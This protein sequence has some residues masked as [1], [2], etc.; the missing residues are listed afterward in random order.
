MADILTKQP[1]VAHS[2][3]QFA[4]SQPEH[5]NWLHF[6]EVSAG[7][8][9]VHVVILLVLIGLAAIPSPTYRAP[10][11]SIRFN[12][13]DAAKLVAPP[14]SVLTQKD[15]NK[16]K[17]STEFNVA[18]LSPRPSQPNT[19]SSPGAAALP[20]QKLTLP[21]KKMPLPSVP[22]VTPDAPSIDTSQL[23]AAAPPPPALGTQPGPP[24]QIQPTEKPKLAFERP[25]VPMG[26]SAPAGVGK[27]PVPS[28]SRSVEDAARQVA[29]GG[30]RGLI[31]GDEDA[32]TL[33]VVRPHP[34]CRS[35]GSSEAPSSC[36]AIRREPI[37]VPNYC[38]C[39]LPCAV[40]GSDCARQHRLAR[41]RRGPV[42]D[43]ARW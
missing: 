12:P 1:V 5:R 42:R 14:S 22:T 10:H 21:D 11:I 6:A 20:K 40:T 24:P 29:R 3:P 25:G 34:R 18:S 16:G 15:P 27:V 23:R 39:S 7:S 9:A 32:S 31:V 2:V 26:T 30:G 8:I 28:P 19:P 38:R 33:A 43:C 35:R 13:R 41:R 17:I 36:S 37:S 4:L